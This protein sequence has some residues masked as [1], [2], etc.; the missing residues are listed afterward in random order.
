MYYGLDIYS[1]NTKKM[2][3]YHSSDSRKDILHLKKM[4]ATNE[5]VYIKECFGETDEDKE[6]YRQSAKY[7][8]TSIAS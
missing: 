2:L 3:A 5:F 8:D 4:Y 1:K 7:G 6:I